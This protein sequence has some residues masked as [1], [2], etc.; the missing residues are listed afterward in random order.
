MKRLGVHWVSLAPRFVGRFEK[1]VDY[2]GDVAVFEREFAV[3]AAI[4]RHV[5]PYK[6][7]LHSGSD[8]FS[9]YGIAA[10]LA[11]GLVH[12]KTAGTSYLEAL[13]ALS[14]ASPAL[15]REIYVFSRDRYETDKQT[16][17][18]SAELDRAPAP[19]TLVGRGAAVAAGALRRPAGAARHVRLGAD[20]R[21]GLRERF[22][23]RNCVAHQAALRHAASRRT[24]RG[25][26]SRLPR[27]APDILRRLAMNLGDVTKFYDFSGKTIVIT[28]A[29][30]ILG[31]EMACALV[32]CDANVAMLDRNLD[33]GQRLLELMGP[34]NASHAVLVAGNVL[35]P[36]SMKQA[37]GH[38]A[39]ALRPGRRAHQRGGRQP[40]QRDHQ[41]GDELLRHA[42]RGDALGDRPQP[43][44]H[45]HPEPGLRQG[46]G[47]ARR[48][49]H[50]QRLV[51]ERLQA[52]DPR[53]RLL[54]REGR[55]SATSRSGWRCTWRRS[56]RP[57]S[58]STPSRR[59]SS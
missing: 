30:G 18:V 48:G 28:G 8:K 25:T 35:E 29:T 9:I 32:G 3:H 1:G 46:D 39:A 38:R 58:A 4:A 57:T 23:D 13:R 24:S 36:D 45:H 34:E 31:G 12:L 56:T 7:S 42:A 20:A 40:S 14:V 5:G 49:R 19:D 21:R 22:T 37:V 53:A 11:R 47:G 27:P 50:P 17:H 54:G 52:A 43:R 51:D 2:I 55:R 15:F 44:G 16:Y 10:R 59:A 26:S 33:P 41:A 6:L